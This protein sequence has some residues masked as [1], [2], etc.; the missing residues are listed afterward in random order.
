M[1]QL[2]SKVPE[3]DLGEWLES[4]EDFKILNPEEQSLILQTVKTLEMRARDMDKIMRAWTLAK[5]EQ[6]KCKETLMNIMLKYHKDN[7]PIS[8]LMGSLLQKLEDRKSL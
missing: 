2:L 5:E 7:F 8:G 3:V 4:E 1:E 6:L